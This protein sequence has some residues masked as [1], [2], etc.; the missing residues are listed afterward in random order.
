[1]TQRER[2]ILHREKE[3]KRMKEWRAKNPEK[4]RES[5]KKWN[6]KKRKYYQRA[7]RLWLEIVS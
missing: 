5:N 2:I 7:Y 6:V 1:M 3:R 4:K